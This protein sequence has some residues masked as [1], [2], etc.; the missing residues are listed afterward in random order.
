MNHQRIHRFCLALMLAAM[1]VRLA[2]QVQAYLDWKH[3]LAPT[4]WRVDIDA[5]PTELVCRT[6][7]PAGLSPVSSAAP[8]ADEPSGELPAA[9]EEDAAP[10]EPSQNAPAEPSEPLT[11]SPEEAD[12]IVITGGCTYTYEKQALLMQ[13]STLDFSG[14]GPKILIVHTHASEAYTP[15]PGFTYEPSDTLRTQD[16][17]RSVIR[18]GSEIARI[19]E[20]A[21]IE[22]LHDTTH[23][24][25]PSYDG[26]YARMQ[27]IIESYLAQY[28]SIQM[29][30]DV[31]RDAV[32]DRAGFPAALTAKIDGEEYARLM[33]VVG[34][35]EGGLTH[36]DWEENLAN[37]LKLQA[38][39]NRRCPG[40]CRNLDLRTE[41][42]NQHETPGSLLAEFGSTGN[43]LREAIR[44]G[45]HFA[46]GLAE[47]IDGLS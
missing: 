16:E 13:P 26:S 5:A 15:E 32:E 37:A 43:T 34:T 1:L 10:E 45:R 11:F 42:F 39:L 33:L 40:L 41:R 25:Y 9:S 12:A 38:I 18:L 46:E 24:D 8:E 3:S 29:V 4:L 28:P 36:P 14:D 20:D 2:G 17:T 27:T 23:N 30:L 47:L 19:L 6:P 31:H 7:L 21:G 35:D 44:A 22:T